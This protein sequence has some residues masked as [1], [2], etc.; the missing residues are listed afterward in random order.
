MT[1]ELEERLLDLGRTCFFL[2]L[3]LCQIQIW[4]P[5]MVR[6]NIQEAEAG[7][8]QSQASL[9]YTTRPC[10]R[11]RRYLLQEF[12]QDSQEKCVGPVAILVIV[13]EGQF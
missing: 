9:S 12:C 3:S 8:F 13:P 5:G 7:E 6:H 4:K 10:F 1:Q 2:I 11:G